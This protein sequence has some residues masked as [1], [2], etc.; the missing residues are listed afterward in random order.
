[1]GPVIPCVNSTEY[2]LPYC[3]TLISYPIDKRIDYAKIDQEISKQML[4]FTQYFGTSKSEE[5]IL[6]R[7]F[8]SC[9][10]GFNRCVDGLNYLE[11]PCKNVCEDVYKT[12]GE[13]DSLI[14]CNT[15]PT[16]DCIDISVYPFY[17]TNGNNVVANSASSILPSY[18]L[19]TLSILFLSYFM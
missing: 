10:M 8:L 13:E 12:C 18:L 11:F 9:A 7:Q 6:K 15:F 1:M 16:Y 14:A 2:S 4:I 5:C 17:T 19:L 3:S